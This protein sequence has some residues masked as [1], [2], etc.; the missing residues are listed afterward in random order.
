VKP[1]T[2]RLALGLAGG[3]A[4]AATT[5]IIS[6]AVPA[7]AATAWRNLGVVTANIGRANLGQRENAIIAV[8]NA[9]SME[10]PQDRPLVGW[11]EIGEGDGDEKEKGWINEHFGPNYNNVHLNNSGHLVP[12]SVPKVYSVLAQRVT[13]VHDGL[14]G[15]SPARVITEVLLGAA[16]DPALKFAFLNTHFVAGAFNGQ[17]D[18]NEAWRDRMWARHFDI[19]KT[20]MQY[21]LSRGYPVIWTGDV[22]RDPMPKEYP[23]REGRPFAHGIDQIGWIESTNGVQIQLRNTKVVQMN[24]DEHNARVAVFQLRRV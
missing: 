6:Q 17:Q 7:R 18:P 10:G 14:A 9:L 12:M 5:D 1:I 15:V 20:T 11:Q 2:R 22:N 23:A 4:L 21:W 13:P 16:D 3:A 24:V 19:L 8:R